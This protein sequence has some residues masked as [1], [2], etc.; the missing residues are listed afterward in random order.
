MSIDPAPAHPAPPATP[1][2]HARPIQEHAS[3]LLNLPQLREL[4]SRKGTPLLS[5]VGDGWCTATFVLAD[6]DADPG[7]A[8]H[9]RS[10]L[11]RSMPHE[12]PLEPVAGKR[13]RAVT[14][15]LPADLR[16]SYALEETRAD[17]T[18]RLVPD[19]FNTRP[20][21][22]D[23][24][25]VQSVAVLPEARPL[26]ILDRAAH[27]EAPHLAEVAL[28][29]DELAEDRRIWVSLPA[30]ASCR[31]PAGRMPVV[32]LFDGSPEH[33]APRVRDALLTAG[34]VR[35][36]VIALVDQGDLRE[37]DLPG[38]LPFSRF[39]VH[40]LLPLLQARFAVSALPGDVILSG[41]SYGGLCAGWTAL[42]FPEA[43]GGAIMQSPSCW[44]HPDLPGLRRD[45][46]PDLV[47]APTPTLVADFQELP[48]APIRI[49]QEVGELELGPPPAQVWQTL[50]NR[51]L[52]TV[53]AAK[54]YDTLYREFAGGHDPAWWRGTWAD[55]LS[56]ML[57]ATR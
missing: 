54:G 52:H 22:Q 7:S 12:L 51:W 26:P 56:W 3:G 14:V 42:H 9:V 21:L 10:L 15:R 16:F 6:P 28:H 32:V 49:Y 30:G 20:Q 37:R 41:S 33:S 25:L 34:E 47:R 19:P 55:A 45:S 53:L 2:P 1:L 40:E 50:G 24:R 18:R 35:P 4:L 36:A 13:I 44:H 17:G 23:P 27:V 57:P 39:I 8:F 43:V 38:S 29:S 11:D 46:P 48:R 31:G 5:P